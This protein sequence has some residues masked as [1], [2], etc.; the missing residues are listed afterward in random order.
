[1]AAKTPSPD[2]LVSVVI[3]VYDQA[4]YLGEAIESVTAQTYPH[5]EIVVVDDGS[6]DDPATVAARHPGVR[7]VRQPNAGSAAARNRGIRESRGAVVVLLDADDR[8]LPDALARGLGALAARPDAAVVYGRA[9]MIAADGS[10]LPVEQEPHR[11]ADTYAALLERCPIWN[12]ASVMCRRS[13]F[14]SGVTFDPSMRYCSDYLFYLTVARQ[15]PM[16]SHDAVVSEYRQHGSNASTNGAAMIR[17]L[18]RAL[19]EQRPFVRQAPRWR[20]ARRRGLRFVCRDYYRPAVR[21]FWRRV[22]S[23]SG[24]ELALRDMPLLLRVTPGVLPR[25]LAG[26]AYRAIRRLVRR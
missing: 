10:R 11:V 16:A 8:L 25:L 14:D 19:R 1:M 7:F 18:T 9:R 3:P 17:H 22:R 20:S 4:R 26:E 24:R 13:V 12:P 23:G 6:R 5:R 15:W 21:D 2:P